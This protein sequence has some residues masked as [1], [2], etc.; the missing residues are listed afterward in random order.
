MDIPRILRQQLK[1]A[2]K[3]AETPEQRDDVIR[4]NNG[5]SRLESEFE[6]PMASAVSF[7]ERDPLPEGDE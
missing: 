6:S 4:W 2:L 5:I 3:A 1:Y 7:A